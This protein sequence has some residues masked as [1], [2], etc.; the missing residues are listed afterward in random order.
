[1]KYAKSLKNGM[2]VEI[3]GC[4][5]RPASG[6]RPVV[7]VYKIAQHQTFY[8]NGKLQRIDVPERIVVQGHVECKGV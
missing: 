3:W 1:M 7:G 8:A 6:K 4:Y 2:V 5:Y